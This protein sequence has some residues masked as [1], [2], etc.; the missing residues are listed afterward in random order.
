MSSSNLQQ[1]R[2]DD[3]PDI[4]GVW[5]DRGGGRILVHLERTSNARDVRGALLALA[6]QLAEAPD[7]TRAVCVLDRSKLSRQRLDDE[8]RRFRQL[9]RRDIGR[10]IELVRLEDLRRASKGAAGAAD[11]A[12]FLSWVTGLVAREATASRVSRQ[13]V[14]SLVALRWLRGA[15]PISAKALQMACGAS[16]P[17]VAA[18]VAEFA[19]LDLIEPRSDRRIALRYLSADRWMQLARKHTEARKVHRYVDPTGHARSP[20]VLVARL[21]E[22][23]RRGAAGNVGVGGVIGVRRYFP[24]VDITAA[25]RL[26]LSAYGAGGLEFVAQLDAALEPAAHARAKAHVVVHVTAEPTALMTRDAGGVWASEMECCADLIELELVREAEQMFEALRAQ[27][28]GDE[29]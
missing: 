11:H 6:Y 29:R 24:D 12:D 15:G 20:E 8:L 14:M 1:A 19:K 21:R 27:A 7:A 25:P 26:D 2:S 17:T 28:Q 16:Y 10:R 4:D 3:P 13:T 18:A 9:I 5:S 22:L 23:Q